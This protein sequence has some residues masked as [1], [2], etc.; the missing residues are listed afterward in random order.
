MAMSLIALHLSHSASI[1]II[2][3]T[4][5]FSPL[6]LQAYYYDFTACKIIPKLERVSSRHNIFLTTPSF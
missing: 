6:C 2:K 4:L 1:K 3:L 5:S